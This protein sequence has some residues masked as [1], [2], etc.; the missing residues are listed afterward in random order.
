MATTD[1]KIIIGLHRMLTDLDRCSAAVVAAH[2]LTLGQFAVLEALY[3]KGAMTVGQVQEKILSSSGTIPLIIRNLEK[4]SLLKRRMDEQDKRKCILV[5]TA[6]GEELIARVYPQNE[7]ALVE[8]LACLADVQK[9]EL[10]AALQQYDKNS[11][12]GK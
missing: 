7:A 1:M 3:H 12:E 11:R 5:L 2:G 9:A 10:L 6:A 8:K 4:R